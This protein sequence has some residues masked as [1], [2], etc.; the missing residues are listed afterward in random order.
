VHKARSLATHLA[1]SHGLIGVF[2]CLAVGVVL[3]IFLPEFYLRQREAA[4]VAEGKTLAAEVAPTLARGGAVSAAALGGSEAAMVMVVD[5]QQQI[6][7][8]SAP[9]GGMGGRGRGWG[10]GMGMGRG[11]IAGADRVWQQQWREILSGRV[12][13]GRV[14]LADQGPIFVAAVP[15]EQ[16]KQVVGAVV[17]HA[18]LADLQGAASALVPPILL[19]SLLV[20]AVAILAGSWVSRRMAQPLRRMTEAA[21]QVAAGNLSRQVE[22]PAWEEGEALAGAFNRMTKSLAAQEATRRQFVADAS[23]QLRAPLTSLQAQAEALLDGMVTDEPTRQRFL[24]RILEDAKG[25]SL[26]AQELLDMERLESGPHAP[27]REVLDLHDMLGGIADSFSSAESVPVVAEADDA[28]PLVVADPSEVRQAVVNLITNALKHSPA[29]G[30]VRLRARRCDA[31]VRVEVTDQGHGI[32]AEYLRL[33]WER[34]YRVPG[35]TTGGSGLGLAITKRLIERQGGRVG[36][37]SE[38]GRSSTFW[39]ELPVAS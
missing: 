38:L 19:A 7:A 1:L 10:R 23:H 32:S 33:V 6:V 29:G 8:M 21:E 16:A 9:R 3:A 17:V 24:A 11:R 28:L 5:A 30:A 4:L 26:L 22:A 34:F 36:A 27:Q 18:R 13:Q 31:M 14:S 20:A 15:V 39:F 25:L 37:E 2:A 35:D 12:V